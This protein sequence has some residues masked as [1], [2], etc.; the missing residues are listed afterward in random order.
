MDLITIV[1]IARIV[2][3]VVVIS[4]VIFGVIQIRHYQHQRHDAAAVQLVNYF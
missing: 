4:G 2:R 1:N 3:S